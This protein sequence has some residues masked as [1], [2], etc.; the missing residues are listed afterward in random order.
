ML[1]A[2]NGAGRIRSAAQ[3]ARQLA[4]VAAAVYGSGPD[5]IRVPLEA[6]HHLVSV[7]RHALTRAEVC[8][9]RI[10]QILISNL[11]SKPGIW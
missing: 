11:D 3:R 8:P 10:S 6:E 5:K 9:T 1:S 7:L 4:A 2:D